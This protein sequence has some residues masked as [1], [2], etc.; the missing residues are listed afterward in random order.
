[1]HEKKQ[2][3]WHTITVITDRAVNSVSTIMVISLYRFL[4]QTGMRNRWHPLTS[5][6]EHHCPVSGR[7]SGS[8]QYSF[9]IF[10]VNIRTT[11][12]R[13]LGVKLWHML[14]AQCFEVGG[15]S[16]PR[17][18]RTSRLTAELLELLEML[19]SES[20]LETGCRENGESNNSA[21]CF[22]ESSSKR[23]NPSGL[24]T[25]MVRWGAW[26]VNH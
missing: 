24:Q 3:H 17:P 16:V 20:R 11:L 22:G 10:T 18:T 8:Y 23:N 4:Y 25:N 7:L 5:L 6:R 26:E 19:H 12:R 2:Q 1:M 15:D 21:S 13:K 14:K 9:T